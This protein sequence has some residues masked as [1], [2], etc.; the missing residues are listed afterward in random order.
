MQMA[1]STN[2][3]L[4]VRP[5]TF[6]SN[7]E[8][9]ASNAF[10]SGSSLDADSLKARVWEAFDSCVTKLKEAGVSV[11]VDQ[12]PGDAPRPDAVF[13][14]NWFSTHED[15]R[16]ALYPMLSPLR[17]AERRPEIIR[18]LMERFAVS[19]IVDYTAYEAEDK[20]LEGTGS[21]VLD[22]QNKICYACVGPRTHPLLVQKFCA[23]FG[24]QAV[25]FGAE[26]PVGQPIY[27]TNVLMTVGTDFAVCCMECLASDED[28]IRVSGVLDETGHR[29]LLISREEMRKFA[30]NMI[31]L[32][33][34]GGKR[35]LVMSSTAWLGLTPKHKEWVMDKIQP[36]IL[37]V[38]IIQDLGGGS[39]RC[40]IAE[41]FLP[42]KV[43]AL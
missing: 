23:D 34:S 33:G 13:P 37:P 24:Y 20:F 12:D 42:S 5:G 6:G 18:N 41:I 22:R 43:D 35:V 30:G 16:V 15:G 11:V 9:L 25:L 10:Q 36:V 29:T 27:H 8:T 14:N 26:D 2:S 31:E 3:V 17:R 32:I 1:Q 4:M 39:A 38:G 19:E 40:M 21:M 28:R 7:P